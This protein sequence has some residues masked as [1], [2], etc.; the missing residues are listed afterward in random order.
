MLFQESA[1]SWEDPLLE[2]RKCWT[3]AQIL[4]TSSDRFSRTHRS[5]SQ[6]Q[7]TQE[8]G[9]GGPHISFWPQQL[10]FALWCATT[11]CG[12]SRDILFSSGSSLDLSPQLRSFYLFHV[13]FTARR[14][15]YEMGGIQS[16]SA[17]PDDPTFNQKNNH[18][19]WTYPPADVKPV[20]PKV[21]G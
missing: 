11:G 1:D 10:N 7:N 6:P 5:N 18:K 16:M 4:D 14:I 12:M 3:Q 19:K 20:K 13:Y 21:C 15:L 17:L 8:R 2:D 9:L